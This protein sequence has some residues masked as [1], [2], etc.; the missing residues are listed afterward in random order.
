[1]TLTL[2]IITALQSRSHDLNF[3]DRHGDTSSIPESG[4]SPGEG[5]GNP[6]QYS[7]LENSMDRGTWWATVQ[8]VAKSQTLLQVNNRACGITGM[9][10]STGRYFS[11]FNP[12][13]F[14]QE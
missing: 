11:R 2:L 1:M 12:R 13:Q 6:L 3:R 4:R 9:F 5:N 8:G 14:R 7:C 10:I